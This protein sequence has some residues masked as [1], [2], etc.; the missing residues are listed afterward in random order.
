MAQRCLVR[1]GELFM[2]LGWLQGQMN[3]LT[4]F[5]RNPEL[6]EPFMA[7]PEVLPSE[8]FEQRVKGWERYFTGVASDFSEAFASELTDAERAEV[9][10]FVHIRN[11][12]GHAHFSFGREYL[13]FRAYGGAAREE[14]IIAELGVQPR[15][16]ATSPTI[17]KL[18]LARDDVYLV[19]FEAVAR[20]DRSC[21]SRLAEGVGIKHS[22]IR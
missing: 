22:R 3:D 9:L 16:G 12:L 20:F 13:L 4:I 17:F 6:V 7:S 21:L 18:E 8:F 15:L 10:R 19:L 14:R 1:A 5:K 2:L 11:L